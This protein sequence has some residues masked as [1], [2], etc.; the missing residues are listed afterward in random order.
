[1]QNQ[2]SFFPSIE[3]DDHPKE[4]VITQKLTET[5]FVSMVIIFTLVVTSLPYLY[6]FLSA[7]SGMKFMG[8]MLDVPDHAQYFSWFHDFRNATLISNK[9]TPEYNRPIFFNLLW[10]GM[11]KIGVLL[12]LNYIVMY[13]LLRFAATIALFILIY[14][15]CKWFLT[16]LVQRRTA[17][18]IAVFT[19]GLGWI[20]VILKYITKSDLLFPQDLFIAEGNTFLGVL[21]YPH[22]IA[23]ALYISVFLLILYGQVKQQLRYAV[24]AGL[25]G[26]FLGWQHTYD[27]VSVYGVLFAYAVLLMLRDKK[28]PWFMVRSGIIVGILSCA[29]A[30]YSV[31]LTTS[32]PVWKKVLAQFANAGVFTPNLLHLPIL[33][34]F[35]LILAVFTVIKMNP[36]KLKGKNDN[37]LFLIGWFLFTFVLIYLPVDYQIHLLNGWQVPMAILATLGLFG[38]VI[39][40]IQ[41][42]LVG[43][44]TASSK[45]LDPVV[46]QRGLLA[47]FLILILPTNIYLWA[48]RFY[49]LSRHTYPYYLHTD[50]LAAMNWLETNGR[51]DDVVLASLT[52]GQY[53]PALTGE[54]SYLGHWAQTLD[55]FGKSADVNAFFNPQTSDTQ[56][57]SILQKGKIRYIF[58]GPAEK[59]VGAAQVESLP[60]L[61]RVFSTPSVVIYAVQ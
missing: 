13:Q 57:E 53:I 59:A 49:D 36:L 48:W 6:G 37:Q 42:H 46:I 10:W 58:V 14:W 2:E 26:L 5:W 61:T 34:G 21:G 55:F 22:F 41:K 45:R 15:T 25:V 8:I 32:D 23:A 28:I 12:N 29:P 40:F 60:G 17:F 16:D 44:P 4:Q 47:L 30:V 19:S 43:S 39:P 33:M 27:L 54:H 35:T 52:I 50:E 7:P 51:P 20:L 18:L 38:Y 3:R 56:R 1:M 24:I 11:A 9:L 31:W